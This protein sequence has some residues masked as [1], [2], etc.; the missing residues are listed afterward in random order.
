MIDVNGSEARNQ[1]T[2][3]GIAGDRLS[4]SKSVSFSSGTDVPGNASAKA[5]FEKVKTS[6]STIQQLLSRD[7]ANIHSSVAAFERADT[8]VKQLFD[9]PLNKL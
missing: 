5:L 3:I 8:K 2:N 1:A 9:S 4:I 7:V 6:S